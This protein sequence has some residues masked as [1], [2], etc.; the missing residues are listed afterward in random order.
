MRIMQQNIDLQKPLARWDNRLVIEGII[1]NRLENDFRELEN[2]SLF[3]LLMLVY[4]LK[5]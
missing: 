3:V 1:E 4:M 5:N 2:A